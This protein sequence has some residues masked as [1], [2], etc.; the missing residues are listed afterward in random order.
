M[1]TCIPQNDLFLSLI[2][3]LKCFLKYY[4]I[5]SKGLTDH[6]PAPKTL[7]I[8]YLVLHFSMFGNVENSAD[9]GI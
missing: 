3:I 4:V 5:K 2:F 1:T 6:F 7:V 9:N 8:L